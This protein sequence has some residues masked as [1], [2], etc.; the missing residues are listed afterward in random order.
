MVR[1]LLPDCKSSPPA[2][3]LAFTSLRIAGG[4]PVFVA[5][6]WLVSDHHIERVLVKREKE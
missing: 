4:R 2:I 5:R 3:P 1:E 6:R